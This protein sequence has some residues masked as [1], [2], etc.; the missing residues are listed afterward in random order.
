MFGVLVNVGSGAKDPNGRGRVFDDFTFEYLPIPETEETICKV[1]TYRELGF[2][3]VKFPDL[4]VHLDPEFETFTYGHVKRGF[5][6]LKSLLNLSQNDVLFFT[7]TLQKSSGW[8]YYVIGYFKHVTIYDCRKL[9]DKK[10]FLL[11]NEGFS[12]NAHLKRKNPSVD[13]LVKGGEGSEL[14]NKAFPL[15]EEGDNLTLAKPLRDI[16]LTSSGKK[17][18]HGTPWFRWTLISYNA[19]KLLEMIK[20]WSK[21]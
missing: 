9:T 12:N 6:D 16:I 19:E 15:A 17:V 11:K 21:P 14:L 1:P 18:K 20:L 7:A 2:S 13:I 8:S 10:I 3:N 5:G 4:P